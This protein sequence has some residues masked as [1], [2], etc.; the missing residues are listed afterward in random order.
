M[1]TETLP[2]S[3]S[4][5]L[6]RRR[7]QAKR[8]FTEKLRELQAIY[9]AKMKTDFVPRNEYEELLESVGRAKGGAMREKIRT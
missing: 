2:G 6:Y 4:A 1:E 7:T 3:C 5:L 8:Q 9:L